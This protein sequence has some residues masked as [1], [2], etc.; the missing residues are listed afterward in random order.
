MF[1]LF[2]LINVVQS[3]SLCWHWCTLFLIKLTI[4]QV[5]WG[6]PPLP[7]ASPSNGLMLG[8]VYKNFSKSP[9]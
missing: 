5:E 9:A 6:S 1:T 8:T 3:S 7:P 4:S 2:K